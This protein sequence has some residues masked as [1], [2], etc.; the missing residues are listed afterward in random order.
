MGGGQL[1]E[2][3]GDAVSVK[4]VDSAVAVFQVEFELGLAASLALDVRLGKGRGSEVD[5]VEL[6]VLSDELFEVVDDEAV[7][8]VL[9]VV[10]GEGREFGGGQ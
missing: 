7:F 10:S 8:S 1:R 9:G 4:N 6:G 5:L 2:I 3:N